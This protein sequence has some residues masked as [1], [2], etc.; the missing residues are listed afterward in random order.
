[1]AGNRLR[2][3]GLVF[4]R[5]LKIIISKP[6]PGEKLLT[7]LLES[8]DDCINSLDSLSQ[9][10]GVLRMIP[11]VTSSEASLWINSGLLTLIFMPGM[12]YP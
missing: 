3:D 4:I 7:A 5:L 10:Q 1:L 2:N 9:K 8:I 12:N 6:F 11:G